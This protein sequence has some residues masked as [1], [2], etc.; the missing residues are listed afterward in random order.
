MMGG[1]LFGAGV[2]RGVSRGLFIL[3]DKGF[4]TSAE[5]IQYSDEAQS[6]Y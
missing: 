6:M 4:A 1:D 5:N 3:S 2:L